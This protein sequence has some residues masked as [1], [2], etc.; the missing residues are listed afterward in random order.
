MKFEFHFSLKDARRIFIALI[1]FEVLLTL[2]Y[3]ADFSLGSPSRTIREFF[4]MDSENSVPM[5]FSTTQLFLTGVLAL[6]LSRRRDGKQAAFRSLFLFFGVAFVF[7]SVDETIQFHEK[8][9][10]VIQCVPWIPG[11]SRWI[12]AY[13]LLGLAFALV[14]RRDLFRFWKSFPRPALIILLGM[15]VFL[16]GAAGLEVIAYM[17]LYENPTTLIYHLEV[18]FEELFEML[19]ATVILYGLTLVPLARERG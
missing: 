6:F 3:V 14:L 4:D 10:S 12:A 8:M 5:W 18:A 13:I 17:F 7:L 1:I 16:L 11:F 9:S 2:V 15:G 19:G